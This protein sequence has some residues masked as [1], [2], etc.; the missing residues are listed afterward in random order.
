MKTFRK[1]LHYFRELFSQFVPIY[2][3]ELISVLIQ[4]KEYRLHR[5]YVS[6]FNFHFV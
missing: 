2:E 5:F 6:I 4:I 3:K 1:F